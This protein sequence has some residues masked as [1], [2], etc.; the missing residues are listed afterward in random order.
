MN[1][2]EHMLTVLAEECSEV[3]KETSKCL[4]FGPME[5]FADIGISNAQ[6]VKREFNDVLAM[7]EMLQA[8]GVLPLEMRDDQMIQNKKL[9]FE[10]ILE[11]SQECGTL[12]E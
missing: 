2:T 7:I 3:A 5:V 12:N 6:R 11:Y 10:K 1:R 8:A 4:R 9:K